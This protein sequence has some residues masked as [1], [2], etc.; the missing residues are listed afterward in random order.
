MELKKPAKNSLVPLPRPSDELGLVCGN[1]LCKNN[2]QENNLLL[3]IK[4][5]QCAYPNIIKS[6]EDAQ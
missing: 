5:R 4:A 3:S 2:L 6:D 1:A